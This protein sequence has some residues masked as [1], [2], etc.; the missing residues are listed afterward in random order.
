M[1]FPDHPF[2]DF[3]LDLYAR[4][5]VA[6]ACLALQDRHGIDVNVLLFCVWLGRAGHPALDDRAMAELTDKVAD[7]HQEIVRELRRI[8]RLLKEALGPV[9]ENLQKALRRRVQKIEL[10][11]EH[12][13]QLVLAAGS[14]DRARQGPA[15][16]RAAV[17]CRNVAAYFAALGVAPDRQDAEHVR[18]VLAGAFP[19]LEP[20]ETR[21]LSAELA[22]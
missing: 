18:P 2:W 4:D 20:A 11:A 7:W 15:A 6:P 3:S 12:V 22:G 13:E 1:D 14:A 10:E 8:R 5:G 9:P 19:D 17:A 21:R 16:D